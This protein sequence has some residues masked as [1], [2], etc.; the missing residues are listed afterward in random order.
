[1]MKRTAKVIN[2]INDTTIIIDFGIL[3]SAEVGQKVRIIDKGE[4]VYNLNNEEIGTLDLIKSELEIVEVYDR[5]S[6]CQKVTRRTHTIFAMS[7]IDLSKTVKSVQKLNINSD[8][9]SGL[10]LP[11]ITPIQKGDIAEIFIY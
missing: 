7:Q 1:M 4:S 8:D 10:K 5:F 6:L 2:I 9:V 3:N 11:D